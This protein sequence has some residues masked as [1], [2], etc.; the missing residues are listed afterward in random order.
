VTMRTNTVRAGLAQGHPQIGTWLSLASP[1]AARFLAR[2][3][4][5][6]IT[7]DLEHSPATWETADACFSAVASAGCVPLARIPVNDLVHIKRTMDC[8]AWGIVV[9]MCN[10]AAEA[11]AAVAACKYH[12]MGHRSVGGA[13]RALSFE[14]TE[15]E[16]FR[17]ANDETLV[18]VQAEHVQAVENC[19]AIFS[20]PGV[21][22][23]F[24]GPND[25]LASMGQEPAMDSDNPDFRDA[26]RMLLDTAQRCGVAPGIHA[27]DAAMACRRI[28]E[29]WRF[30]AIGSDLTFMLDG[31]RAAAAGVPREGRM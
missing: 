26:L 31:A 10:T 12:P 21:D 7:L 20:T 30:V 14:T 4:L 16:Y 18:V 8:G 3:G 24:V 6:W 19:E 25:L 5:D 13:L 15:A 28:E 11:A 23:M 27:G 2:V 29:G 9:P 22:A 17:R 1:M